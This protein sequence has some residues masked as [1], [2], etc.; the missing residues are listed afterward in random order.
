MY[1]PIPSLQFDI[2]AVPAVI[3]IIYI[4]SGVVHVDI[5]LKK[6]RDFIHV[7]QLE[8]K[9][10]PQILWDAEEALGLARANRWDLLP[11]EQRGR[12]EFLWIFHGKKRE[13]GWSSP[14]I[15]DFS[16]IFP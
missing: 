10:W 16:M 3:Y 7:S 5:H 14:E 15:P 8:G 12:V 11:G 9:P 6:N 4:P 1:I 2:P 13:N